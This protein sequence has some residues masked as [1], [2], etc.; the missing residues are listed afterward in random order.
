MSGV[1]RPSTPIYMDE[2]AWK[3]ALITVY[4]RSIQNPDF[5]NLCLSDPVAAIK[6]ATGLDVPAGLNLQF[7]EKREDLV[8][9]FLLPPVP[10]TGA[11]SGDQV[12]QMI[13]WATL[14]TDLTTTFTHPNT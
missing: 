3:N 9:S 10:T 13:R 1:S 14:C 12:Q 7:V 11:A 4:E 2:L 8:Y 6:E 5:R